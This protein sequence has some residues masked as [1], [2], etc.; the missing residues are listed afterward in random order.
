ML[1]TYILFLRTLVV[2]NFQSSKLNGS[3]GIYYLLLKYSELLFTTSSCNMEINFLLN[4]IYLKLH[5][6]LLHSRNQA[7]SVLFPERQATFFKFE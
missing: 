3:V 6:G 5:L 1:S 4:Y 2:E 7:Y